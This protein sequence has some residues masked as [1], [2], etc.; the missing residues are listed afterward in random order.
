MRIAIDPVS[1]VPVSEQLVAR[2]RTAIERGRP[3]P[4]ER[5]PPVRELASD[6]GLAPN[7]VAK[8]YRAL[9]RDGYLVAR[10]R[11]GT[12][13]ADTL[14]AR[15]DAVE[16]R[17]REAADVFARRARHLGAR[18]ADALDAVRRALRGRGR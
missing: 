3:A 11:A 17:L 14:P 5:L 10:G 7:T 18:D 12:F 15:P 2:L 13:V 16:E 8:A 4:G 6:L 9:E 1:A